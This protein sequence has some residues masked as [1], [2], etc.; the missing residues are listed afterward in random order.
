MDLIPDYPE[1]LLPGDYIAMATEL[2]NKAQRRVYLVCLN[3]N[4]CPE[5]T[6]FINAILSAAQRGVDVH[7]GADLLTFICD[8]NTHVASRVVGPEMLRTSKLRADFIQAGAEFHWL[9]VQRVPYLLGRTHSKWTIIDDDIFAFG[10]VN[11]SHSGIAERADYMF[12]LTNAKLADRLVKEQLLIETPDPQRRIADV[13]IHTK[14]GTVL[15]DSG[16]FGRSGI[17]RHALKLAKEAESLLVVSQYCPT[18]KLGR[19]IRNK[20]SRVYFNPKGSA[21]DIANN[22]MIGSKKTTSSQENLYTRDRYIHS[23]FIIATMPNG[24]KKAITGSHN[25]A[26]ISGRAGTREV[27]IETTDPNIIRQLED[28]FTNEIK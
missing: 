24:S 5:T 25:Y 3:I 18:G 12:H 21:N 11:L 2:I 4:R 14:Y 10:G 23:K 17:Y 8:H 13:N 1:L 7:V 19:I 16:R 15:L 9:G 28:F 26:A 20:D 6:E 27:A 22:F